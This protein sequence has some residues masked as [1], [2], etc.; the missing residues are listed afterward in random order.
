MKMLV[1]ANVEVFINS[2]LGT[3]QVKNDNLFDIKLFILK[4]NFSVR[5][6]LDGVLFLPCQRSEDAG[7]DLM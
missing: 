5:Y 6:D 2:M 7:I 3:L 1:L 4:T